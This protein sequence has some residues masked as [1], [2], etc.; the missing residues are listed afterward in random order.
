MSLMSIFHVFL[1]SKEKFKCNT[2]LYKERK[3]L[4]FDYLLKFCLFYS[5]VCGLVIFYGW[6]I[7]WFSQ[8][9]VKKLHLKKARTDTGIKITVLNTANTGKNQSGIQYRYSV[10]EKIRAVLNNSIFF[11]SGIGCGIKVCITF[12]WESNT[13]LFCREKYILTYI[14]IKY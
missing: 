2:L 11:S 10:P 4:E 9:P 13:I 8:W 12:L 1:F 7:L 6:L 14:D 3:M 5:H